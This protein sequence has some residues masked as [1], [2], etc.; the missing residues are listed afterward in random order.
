MTFGI[1]KALLNRVWDRLTGN[2]Q[3][4]LIVLA[5]AV[6]AYFIIPP[7]YSWLNPPPKLNENQIQRGE[8]AKKAGN[9]AELRQILVESDAAE[10]AAVERNVNSKSDT[11]NAIYESRKKWESATREEIQ[12]EFDRRR[13]Q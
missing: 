1:L 5:V 6:T 13:P 3:V 9:D 12:A 8:A 2:W 7:I 11:V 4:V 10:A